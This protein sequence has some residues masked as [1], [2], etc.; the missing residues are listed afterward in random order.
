MHETWIEKST[1]EPGYSRKSKRFYREKLRSCDSFKG[2]SC[3]TFRFRGY[4]KSYCKFFTKNLQR[5]PYHIIMF[6]V[7]RST[8]TLPI[9]LKKGKKLF[10]NP[11]FLRDR[12]NIE[13]KFSDTN[14]ND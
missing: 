8:R 12:S 10:K 11:Y 3:V 4:F 6:Q 14:S 5:I 2:R 7:R 9:P 13:R 1:V